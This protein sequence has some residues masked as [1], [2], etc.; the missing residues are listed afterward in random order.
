MKKMLFVLPMMLFA[1]TMFFQTSAKAAVTTINYVVKSGDTLNSIANQYQLGSDEILDVNPG[2][3][4]SNLTVG[5]TI[6][7]PNLTEIKRLQEEVVRLTN[8]ERSKVGLSPVVSDW[9]VSRVARYK[10]NDMRD[11]NYF[12]HYSPTY[13]DPFIMLT[14]FGIGFNKAGEN[15]GGKK[16]TPQDVVNGWMASETHRDTMLNPL[17]NK[18]GVGYSSGGVLGDYWVQMFIQG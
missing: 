10:A 3:N 7:I 17:Y 16:V 13:G 12:S 5:N 1:F 18:L 8:V 2:L 14:D 6:K 11:N 4:S 9:K 15:I